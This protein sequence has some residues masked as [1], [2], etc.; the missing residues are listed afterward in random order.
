M[1][2]KTQIIGPN[3]WLLLVVMSWVILVLFAQNRFEARFDYFHRPDGR[4]IITCWWLFGAT[5]VGE[6]LC[7][8]SIFSRK[9]LVLS[10]VSSCIM[11]F[12]ATVVNLTT[13]AVIFGPH[14]LGPSYIQYSVLGFLTNGH[15]HTLWRLMQNDRLEDRISLL[16]TIG[17]A[18]PI[19]ITSFTW[20]K[21]QPKD[22]V[23]K[24]YE[25]AWR[26]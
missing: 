8:L 7:C 14:F 3:K 5:L 25:P 21:R 22:K 12:S 10:I 19:L 20:P 16:T 11:I 24:S 15:Y 6:C 26:L 18:G 1:N 2:A 17:L 4:D 23:K 9:K 13:Y